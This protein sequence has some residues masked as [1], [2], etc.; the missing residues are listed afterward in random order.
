MALTRGITCDTST[1]RSNYTFH[2]VVFDGVIK[3]NLN[4]KN[5]KGNNNTVTYI[6]TVVHT[7][8]VIMLVKVPITEK[9][10]CIKNPIIICV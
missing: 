2:N 4:V 5:L 7:P 10:R 6:S 8:I 3:K 1:R 9:L